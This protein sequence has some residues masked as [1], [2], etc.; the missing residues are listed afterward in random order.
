[1]ARTTLK[2][3]MVIII[4]KLLGIPLLKLLMETFMIKKVTYGTILKQVELNLGEPNQKTI[5]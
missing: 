4:V 5:I 3:L 1:M 2:L